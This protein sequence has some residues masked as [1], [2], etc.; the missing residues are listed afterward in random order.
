MFKYSLAV[1]FSIFFTS[2]LAQT[3]IQGKI[4]DEASKP[5]SN[6]SITVEN[7]LD[8]TIFSFALSDANG[9]YGI[10]LNSDRPNLLFRIK[11]F[12]F[13]TQI[14]TILNVSQTKNFTLISK[15]TKLKEVIVKKPPIIK[16]SD[17]LSYNL[18]SFANSQDRTL[19]DVLKKIPGIDVGINGQIRYQGKAINKFYVEGKDLMGGSYGIITNALPNIDVT[20]VEVLKNHQPITMLRDKVYSADAAINIKLKKNVTITGRGEVGSGLLPAL[21]SVKLT[22]IIF[23][24]KYQSLISYKSNNVGDDIASEFNNLILLSGIEISNENKSPANWLNLAENGLPTIDQKRYLFNKTHTG[25]ANLL[26]NINKSTEVKSNISYVNDIVDRESYERTIIKQFNSFGD[27][28]DSIDFIRQSK[29]K[30]SRQELKTI[31]DVTQNNKLR[32]LKNSLIFQINRENGTSNLTL[33]GFPVNQNLNSPSYTL[34]NSFNSLLPYG[35][36]RILSVQ[37]RIEYASDDQIYKI[38]P[39][40]ALAFADTVFLLKDQLNQGIIN[41]SFKTLTS[42]SSLFSFGNLTLTPKLVLET[43]KSNLNSTL[44]ASSHGENFNDL[45]STYQ[46]YGSYVKL[47][48]KAVAE[49]NYISQRL[50]IQSSLPFMHNTINAKFADVIGNKSLKQFTFEPTAYLDYKITSFFKFILN[51]SRS[52]NF[53]PLNEL[54]PNF[55]FSGLDFKAFRSNI[56]VIKTK[57]INSSVNYENVINNVFGSIGYSFNEQQ[58]NIVIRSKIIANGQRVSEAANIFN[59]STGYSYNLN[60]G[61]FLPKIK[62]N[63]AAGYSYTKSKI[64][65]FL[66]NDVIP[67]VNYGQNFHLK[68]NYNQLDWL[69]LNYRAVLGFSSQYSFNTK[70]NNSS[71]KQ[72]AEVFVSPEKNHSISFYGDFSAF[73]LKKRYYTNPFFDIKYRYTLEKKKIDFELKFNNIFNKYIFEQV[74]FSE[75]QIRETNFNI[76]PRQLLFSVNFNFR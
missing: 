60:I 8:S 33:N 32:F 3:K 45:G 69:G 34:Q 71:L 57:N 42:L 16:R 13:N 70:T 31:M 41:N 46:N 19:S 4:I 26:F 29:V 36:D 68:I 61:K 64:N 75:T 35:K 27:L 21:W 67:V 15:I 59:T 6:C 9:D 25:S 12:N 56:G 43:D 40:S 37:S 49:I 47:I 30:L 10:T 39:L 65:V 7:S 73:K 11:K 66:N 24:K 54:Y 17:T 14:I 2:I 5:I 76:R 62:T 38:S 22:P 44:L 55:V 52:V 58:N 18:E 28:A 50:K 63:I 20:T 1:I 23:T 48:G 53:S 74:D 72:V 51:G